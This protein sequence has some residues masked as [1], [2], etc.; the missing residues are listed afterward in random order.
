[1]TRILVV[2]AT[3]HGHTAK[4]AGAVAGTLR[5][6]GAAVDVQQ[7]GRTHRLPDSY[8]GV[9]VAA[10]VRGGKYLKPMRR[11][12]RAHARA[13]NA[14]P[15]GFVSVC[16][17]ILQHDAAVDR[18]LSTILSRFLAET[19]WQPAITRQV[20]GAL[21][22]TRY[23]WFIR[24]VMKRIA[25]KAGGDTDATRDYEYT[26]WEDLRRFTEEFNRLAARHAT[27]SLLE[28]VAM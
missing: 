14:R 24:R 4:I 28:R 5:A 6:S 7:I 19:G 21:P 22:Y 8:D 15:T 23:N 17:G 26:D 3:T 13:L 1:V 25:A 2:Y 11:W 16:L 18:T 10:P 12:V 20:A 9:I 27:G